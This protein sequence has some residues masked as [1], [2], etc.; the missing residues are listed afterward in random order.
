MTLFSFKVR[1]SEA[2]DCEYLGLTEAPEVQSSRSE[3]CIRDIN[4]EELCYCS[5]RLLD[6]T[7]APC[8]AALHEIIQSRKIYAGHHATTTQVIEII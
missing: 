7:N 4:A 8:T 1:M 5:S 6:L 3:T 2:R